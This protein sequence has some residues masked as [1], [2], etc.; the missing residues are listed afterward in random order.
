[1]T[2]PSNCTILRASLFFLEESYL[3]VKDIVNIFQALQ[4]SKKK[5]S[6]P[7]T[8]LYYLAE[9][10]MFMSKITK[11]KPQSNYAEN[12]G[13]RHITNSQWVAT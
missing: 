1:M 12:T 8:Y 11:R 10:F 13:S 9:V 6:E 5:F 4:Q 2:E 7:W 3:P